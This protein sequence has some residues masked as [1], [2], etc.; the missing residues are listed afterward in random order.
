VWG[1]GDRGGVPSIL[2]RRWS[3]RLGAGKLLIEVLKRTA[4]CAVAW[5]SEA[6]GTVK[7]MGQCRERHRSCLQTK[8]EPLVFDNTHRRCGLRCKS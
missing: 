1:C 4:Q 5:H 7:H 3:W 8:L 6:H 2:A